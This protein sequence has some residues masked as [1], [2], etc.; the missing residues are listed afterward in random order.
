MSNGTVEPAAAYRKLL[1]DDLPKIST[2]R[3]EHMNLLA[4][5]FLFALLC[6]SPALASAFEARDFDSISRSAYFE[7]SSEAANAFANKQYELALPKFQRLACAG[8]KPAQYMLGRMYLAGQGIERDDLQ[9]YLWLKLA[10]EYDFPAYR[11]IVKTIESKLKPEQLKFTAEPAE[12][13]RQRY[14]LR[15]TSISCNQSSSSSY[16]SNLKDAVICT[17]Q[18]QADGFLLRKC[19]D[20]GSTAQKVE[21]PK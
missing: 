8:D 10:A 1:V 15:A 12:T 4:R 3:E 21:A 11:S 5:R 17:P 9:G 14:G 2:D 6:L 20:Q 7:L 13:M 19:V 16:S 18:A